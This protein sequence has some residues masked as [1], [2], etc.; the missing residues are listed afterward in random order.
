MIMQQ[1]K[2]VRSV[3]SEG[4]SLSDALAAGATVMSPCPTRTY[5]VGLTRGPNPT[6]L[7]L[8]VSEAHHQRPSPHF[9][10][11]QHRSQGPLE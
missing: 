2:Q 6:F 5:P 10:G 1:G 4:T 7:R 8:S 3:V 9:G 11:A